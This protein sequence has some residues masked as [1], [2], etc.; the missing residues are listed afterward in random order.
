MQ[1][2]M[3]ELFW[4]GLGRKKCDSARRVFLKDRERERE[5]ERERQRQKERDRV[6]VPTYQRRNKTEQQLVQ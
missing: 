6:Q 4:P 3:T 5:R 1:E 2:N